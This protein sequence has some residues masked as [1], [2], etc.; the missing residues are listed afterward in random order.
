MKKFRVLLSVAIIAV[1]IISFA[2]F[3]SAALSDN[4]E[5]KTVG[6]DISIDQTGEIITI[7]HNLSVNTDVIVAFADELGSDN[8]DF[9]FEIK[10][11]SLGLSDLASGGNDKEVTFG[12]NITD[13]TGFDYWVNKPQTY[14]VFNRGGVVLWDDH[15]HDGSAWVPGP[16]ELLVDAANPGD[17]TIYWDKYDD[18]E[19]WNDLKI[20]VKNSVLNV[21]L[22]GSKILEDYTVVHPIPTNAQLAFGS[23]MRNSGQTQRFTDVVFNGVNLT[24]PEGASTPTTAP[25]SQETPGDF[26]SAALFAVPAILSLGA[27][28]VS[29]KRK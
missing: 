27:I 16:G 8:T 7:G 23:H 14:I 15:Y 11:S 5:A 18:S 28:A 3:A 2:G 9:T 6:A 24:A 17:V 21:W 22:N 26:A 25:T 12:I 4:F 10:V 20:E 1:M 29:K 19:R 13:F